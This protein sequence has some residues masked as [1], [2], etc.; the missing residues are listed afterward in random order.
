MKLFC[1][2]LC[3]LMSSQLLSA[4]G[5]DIDQQ[6]ANGKAGANELFGNGFEHNP[7][8]L[9]AFFDLQWTAGNSTSDIAGL[10]P[11]QNGQSVRRFFDGIPGGAFNHHIV[12]HNGPP[13]SIRYPDPPVYHDEDGGY[14][15][16]PNVKNTTYGVNNVP[17][18]LPPLEIYA[19]IRDLQ[20]V[21][22]EGYF[23]NWIGLR[24]RE[25]TLEMM[26]AEFPPNSGVLVKNKITI[27]RMRIDGANSRLWLNGVPYANGMAVTVPF[28]AMTGIGYGTVSHGANHDFFGIWVKINGLLTESE[29]QQVYASLAS[30]YPPGEF[31]QKPLANNARVVMHTYGIWSCDYDYVNPLGLPEGATEYQWYIGGGTDAPGP[32]DDFLSDA[33]PLPGPNA[34]N[35]TLVRSDYASLLTTTQGAQVGLVYCGVTVKD[36]AGNSWREVHVPWVNNNF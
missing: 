31:P 28:L 5:A 32:Y 23:A 25:H 7:H 21:P 9:S 4:P 35:K 34:R 12:H 6:R 15:W 10:N 20:G 27:I 17:A 8:D 29:H 22:Y 14:V 3:V 18:M 11:I 36:S 2:G 13:H 1:M 26:G 19:V 33:Y 16:F 24:D 30:R